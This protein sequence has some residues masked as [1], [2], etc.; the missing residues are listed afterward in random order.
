MPTIL[1][2][3]SMEPLEQRTMLSAIVPLTVAEPPV[4]P[5]Y[6]APVLDHAPRRSGSD[7]T[8]A[9][10][11][12]DPNLLAAIRTALDKPTGDITRADMLSLRL[13]GAP[14]LNGYDATRA[15]ASLEGLQYAHNLTRLNFDSNAISDLRPISG[16]T[17]LRELYLMDNSI[18]DL[19]PIADLTRLCRLALDSNGI[20]D[21]TPLKHLTGLTAL[22]LP[23]NRIADVSPL[24]ALT[25]LQQL[26]LSGNR[27]S[28]ID[29]LKDLTDL[30][31]LELSDNRVTSLA[32]LNGMHNLQEL[33]AD[34]NRITDLAPL[35][36]LTKLNELELD[37]NRI[38]LLHPLSG[39]TALTRLTLRAN[40]IADVSPLAGLTKLTW[41]DLGGTGAKDI[42][43]LTSLTAL[44]VLDLNH[45][46]ISNLAPVV[47]KSPRVWVNL[48]QNQITDLTPLYA[49]ESGTIVDVS[50]NHLDTTRGSQGWLTEQ[51]LRS[52]G[53]VIISTPQDIPP[54]VRV[55]VGAKVH[56]SPLPD[57]RPRPLSFGTIPAGQSGRVYTF[58]V[59]ADL[60]SSRT[61]HLGEVSVPKGF[62]LL[63][64]LPKQLRSTKIAAFKVQFV[65]GRPGTYTGQIV[66]ATDDPA[67]RHFRI[68]VLGTAV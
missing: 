65:G 7:S 22:S 6:T 34:G 9:V 51:D 3:P 67:H 54:R 52:R 27:L 40:T 4:S 13:L 14:Q 56:S 57:N 30:A 1:S 28:T 26:W 17:R 8:S 68:N 23:Y 44:Q 29:A 66:F 19:R 32:P 10:S 20:T 42:T 60:T 18:S 63:S 25:H 41:L 36:R 31:L 15:V 62:K 55:V 50:Y 46:G 43:S 38:S 45:N 21:L 5:A 37:H 48:S 35:S 53:I 24:G 39:L 61:L 16:L 11:I 49:M 12:P 33:S 47:N 58:R 2:R 59:A 64:G